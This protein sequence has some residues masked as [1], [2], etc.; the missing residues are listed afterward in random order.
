VREIVGRCRSTRSGEGEKGGPDEPFQR[1]VLSETLS[2]AESFD[3]SNAGR[4]ELGE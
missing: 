2:R 4:L 3:A 1:R